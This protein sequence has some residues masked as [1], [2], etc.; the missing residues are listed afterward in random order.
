SQRV[1]TSAR[2]VRFERESGT[3]AAPP[4]TTT[5]CKALLLSPRGLTC[6]LDNT[7]AL[8]ASLECC[9]RRGR[10]SAEKHRSLNNYEGTVFSPHFVRDSEVKYTALPR[11]TTGCSVS[12][13]RLPPRGCSMRHRPSAPFRRAAPKRARGSIRRVAPL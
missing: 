12:R 3:L 4:D 5:V 1:Q 6:H 7:D 13:N 8:I 2:A 10:G 9:D 11:D